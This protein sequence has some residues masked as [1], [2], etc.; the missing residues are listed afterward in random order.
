MSSSKNLNDFFNYLKTNTQGFKDVINLIS[1]DGNFVELRDEEAAMNNITT[2]LTIARG[3][4]PFDPTLGCDLQKYI[5]EWS[6]ETNKAKIENEV[7]EA[8]KPYTNEY[9]VKYEIKYLRGRKGFLINLSLDS[10][11]GIQITR[12]VVVDANGVSAQNMK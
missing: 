6:T 3:T 4:Y 10:I 7:K 2:M 1:G 5:Y 12:Q 9:N 8:I 11:K